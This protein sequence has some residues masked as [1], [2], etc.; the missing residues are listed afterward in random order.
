[1]AADTTDRRI[2]SNWRQCMRTE[3]RRGT[4]RTVRQGA[5]MVRADG[6]A[7]GDCLMAD[8][9]ATGAR[10]KVETPEALPDRFVLLLSH[11]G[12]LRRQCSVAWRSGNAV[13]VRFEQNSLAK[14]RTTVD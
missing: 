11:N 3:H 6:S 9:S 4:R 1:M 10:L 14:K 5:R 12:Q 2:L 8:V 13:G 7:L